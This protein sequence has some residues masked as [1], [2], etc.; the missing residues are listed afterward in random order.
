MNF[1]GKFS[2]HVSLGEADLG[3]G[4]PAVD[5]LQ[6]HAA[7]DAVI[8]PDARLLFGGHYARAGADLVIS[9]PEHGDRFVVSDYFHGSHRSWLSSLDGARLSPDNIRALV[10]EVEVAQAGPGGAPA[11]T[12][13][14]H[15]SKMSGSATA[16]RNGVAVELHEGDQ[17]YKGDVVQAGT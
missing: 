13:I 17:V 1:V 15:V 12:P 5:V 8:V 9:Y 2:S 7:A 10:G 16:I 3:A 4:H 14:G 6:H 11:S